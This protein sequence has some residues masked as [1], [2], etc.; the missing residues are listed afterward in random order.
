MYLN[1]GDKTTISPKP[2]PLHVTHK[3]RVDF[4]PASVL[5]LSSGV[6]EGECRLLEVRLV[7]G[8]LVPGEGRTLQLQGTQGTSFTLPLSLSRRLTSAF[9]FT[10]IS[11]LTLLSFI[12]S[13]RSPPPPPLALAPEIHLFPLKPCIIHTNLVFSVCAAGLEHQLLE[14]EGHLHVTHFPGV[15]LAVRKD[16]VV[17]ARQRAS[18]VQ[19]LN[20]KQQNL[21][22]PL[23]SS[24]LPYFVSLS[25]LSLSL[26]KLPLH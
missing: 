21:F 13:V 22:L 8:D 3:R 7:A 10:F 1:C 24:S 12:S 2:R 18:Q 6:E 20:K 9:V 23:F 16:D 17:V 26:S 4:D 14:T 15:T 19:K 5:P 25:F 11:I